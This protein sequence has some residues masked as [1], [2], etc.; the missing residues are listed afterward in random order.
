MLVLLDRAS[1][2][3]AFLA[4]VHASGAMVLCRAKG[5][6]NRV[7]AT[8]GVLGVSIGSGERGRHA[9]GTERQAGILM[10]TAKTAD[11]RPEL[12]GSCRAGDENRTRTISLGSRAVTAARGVDLAS[13]G[14][15]S[16]RG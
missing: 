5:G 16:N 15:P 7:S 1:G 3:N 4:E 11:H 13:S 6:F 9:A 2:S 10:L 14:V 12:G 8:L